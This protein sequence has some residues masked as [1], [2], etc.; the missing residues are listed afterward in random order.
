MSDVTLKMDGLEKLVKA[1]KKKPPEIRVGILQDKAYRSDSKGVNNATIGAAHEYGTSKLPQRSFLRVPLGTVLGPRLEASGAVGKD[2]LKEVVKQGTFLPWCHKIGVLAVDV[3][4]GAFDSDG[5]GQWKPSD[6]THK[7][8]H[9]TLV[10]S[11]QL[12]NSIFYDVK[13]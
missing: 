1:L 2:E 12:R 10:E 7:K 4:L 3:V 9:Q 13:E 5:Y 6:M 11:G 8:N